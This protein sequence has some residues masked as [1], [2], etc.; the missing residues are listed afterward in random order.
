MSAMPTANIQWG[1]VSSLHRVYVRRTPKGGNSYFVVIDE[2]GNEAVPS[3][4]GHDSVRAQ[5]WLNRLARRTEQK[6]S[7]A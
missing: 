6:E 1:D 5:E 7:K 2:D 3:W 4:S